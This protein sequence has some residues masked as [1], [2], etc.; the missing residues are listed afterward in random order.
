MDL[1]ME[2]GGKLMERMD[3]HVEN[4]KPRT[5]TLGV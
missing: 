5:I 1:G 4:I 3:L 2:N